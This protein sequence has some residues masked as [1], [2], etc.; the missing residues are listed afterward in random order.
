MGCTQSK[1][2]SEEAVV[3]C[4]ER[5]RFMREAVSTRGAFAAAHVNYYMS[6]KSTGGALSEYAQYEAQDHRSS[7]PLTQH[8]IE[9][10]PPPPPLPNFPPPPLQRAVTMPEFSIPRVDP[11]PTDTIQEEDEADMEDE[12]NLIRRGSRGAARTAET[13]DPPRLPS[14]PPP[15]PPTSTP[16]LDNP[17][18]PPPE[19][20]DTTWDYFFSA[21]TLRPSLSEAEE[22]KPENKEDDGEEHDSESN[23]KENFVADGDV[24]NKVEPRMQEKV[25]DPPVKLMKKPKQ[26]VHLHS[27]SMEAKRIGKVP[28][29]NF[30]QILSDIDDHFLKA[31]ESA[32]EVSKM[33]EANRLHYHSNF[34]DNR[35]LI[36]HSAKVM[37][38]ITWNRSFKSLANVDDETDELDSEV[39]ETHA[40]VLDKL[41]AWEKKLYDEVKVRLSLN[42]KCESFGYLEY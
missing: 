36:N 7:Q 16:P 21:H 2:E 14:P 5:K 39:N 13:A 11:R 30:S 38:V 27:P 3:R 6:L 18:P 12:S 22:I 35:G 20:S 25:D 32:Q 15:P 28:N 24:G 8:P 19:H 9:T 1:I 34:A 31:S 17:V 40:A 10:L 26:V 42:I 37:R 41:L 4:K 23:F 29:A 33:L